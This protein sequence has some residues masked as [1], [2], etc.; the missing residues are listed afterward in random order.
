MSANIARIM[1]HSS[2]QWLETAVRSKESDSLGMVTVNTHLD[3]KFRH[4]K[5]IF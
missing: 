5:R 1:T 3:D 4:V 2:R